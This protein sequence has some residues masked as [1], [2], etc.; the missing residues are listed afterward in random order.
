MEKAYIVQQA[1]ANIV[2]LKQ[3]CPLEIFL[4]KFDKNGILYYNKKKKEV[5]LI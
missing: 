5:C 1:S 2:N 3:K 4:S